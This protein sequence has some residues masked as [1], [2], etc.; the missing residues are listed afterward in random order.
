MTGLCVPSLLESRWVWGAGF[1]LWMLG[2]VVGGRSV[3]C[4]S[5]R[6]SEPI[7]YPVAK[8]KRHHCV[9]S[10]PVGKMRMP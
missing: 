1:D 6:K 4:F 5:R 2:G 7:V 9:R 8:R 10:G 3:T